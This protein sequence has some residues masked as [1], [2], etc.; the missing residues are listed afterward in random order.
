M[1]TYGAHFEEEITTK[2]IATPTQ[3]LSRKRIN[4]SITPQQTPTSKILQK[5]QSTSK[6]SPAQK[7]LMSPLSKIP[8]RIQTKP[9]KSAATPHRR[10]P[11][12]EIQT[13]QRRATKIPQRILIANEKENG[14]ILTEKIPST[15]RTIAYNEAK[16]I[17]TNEGGKTVQR[18]LKKNYAKIAK[19]LSTNL[20]R[21]AAKA[22]CNSDELLIEVIECIAMKCRSEID[23]LSGLKQPSIL[24]DISPEHIRTIDIAQMRLE[25]SSRAKTMFQLLTQILC[26]NEKEAIILLATMVHLEK[27]H[28]S[29]FA[30]KLGLVARKCG[31]NENGLSMLNHLG[32]TS[33]P[34]TIR[35]KLY[36]QGINHDARL[37]NWIELLKTFQLIIDNL[38]LNIGVKHQTNKNKTSTYHWVNMIAIAD[39]V[40]GDHLSDFHQRHLGD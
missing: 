5:V 7:E 38:D 37:L 10:T 2:R 4:F 25:F 12:S 17:E 27:K 28:L 15:S 29:A 21:L 11:L 39:P 24:R 23:G 31:M 18:T 40:F 36:E 32:L 1:E 34:L 33:C 20:T 16:V 9:P 8:K 14:V 19:Y 13:I 30:H 6:K 22:I 3:P 26:S 35:E